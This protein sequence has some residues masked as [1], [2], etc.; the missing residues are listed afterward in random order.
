MEVQQEI[1]ERIKLYVGPF[2]HQ[3]LYGTCWLMYAHLKHHYPHAEPWYDFAHGHIYAK[4]DGVCY[5][6]KGALNGVPDC[7]PRCF[8][9]L[10][11]TDPDNA[12]TFRC[13]REASYEMLEQTKGLK[14]HILAV[15]SDDYTTYTGR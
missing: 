4:I 10:D 2:Q 12:R 8:H 15:C 1:L 11:L 3:F 9:T 14:D 5:D 6:A 7:P 13:I